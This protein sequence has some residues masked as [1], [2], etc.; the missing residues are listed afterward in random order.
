MKRS[1]F[2]IS[3]LTFALASALHVHCSRQVAGG[4]SETENTA[5]AG[6]ILTRGGGPATHTRVELLPSSYSPVN[7]QKLPDSLI[8]TTGTDGRYSFRGI[9]PGTY[10]LEAIQLTSGQRCVVQD[11]ATSSSGAPL[12][13]GT[14]TLRAAATLV[15]RLP[16]FMDLSGG[17]VYAPGTSAWV[18]ID[19]SALNNGRVVLDSV[20][21][22]TYSA[23][24][25]SSTGDPSIAEDIFGRVALVPD[26]VQT[27][28]AGRAGMGMARVILNT[29]ASGAGIAG[30]NENFPVLVRLTSDNF[31]FGLAQP[32]GND[33][34]FTKADGT[35]MAFEVERWDDAGRQAD[36][37]VKVD[38]VYGNDS[39]QY[40]MMFWGVS[41]GPTT[42][43]AKSKVASLST[44]MV[45]TGANGYCGV[46]HLS[47]E[48]PGVGAAGVYKDAT[49]I[50][51]DGADMVRSTGRTGIIGYGHDFVDTNDYIEVDSLKNAP[52]RQITVSAWINLDTLKSYCD[53]AYKYQW[54]VIAGS[55]ALFTDSTGYL[56]FGI[57]DGA[58]RYGGCGGV[59]PGQWCYVTGV[60][61]G[62][63]VKA[64]VNGS[65]GPATSSTS[66]SLYQ[67]GFFRI[68]GY[69]AFHGAVDEVCIATVARTADWIKLCY[70]NQKSPNALVN[71]K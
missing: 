31:N 23:I 25:Y 60:Y 71:V 59:R 35:A 51:N 66:I 21:S 47:E 2:G 24:R 19:D 20:P 49:G 14:D 4:A 39:A 38:T 13:L 3:I 46:W 57:F 37:W 63:M 52:G 68:S 50:G 9:G 15:V 5:V 8:D 29:S 70:M 58:R 44:G 48:M 67:K 43:S 11:V 18:R 10:S 26:S 56:N 7:G 54:N 64:Y 27:V 53:V 22:A 45:F 61:D 12:D 65:A 28:L 41:I 30:N 6:L 40:F 55:W 42:D 1:L 32:G 36:V 62:A 34:R 69:N 33:V 16:Y 17:Y